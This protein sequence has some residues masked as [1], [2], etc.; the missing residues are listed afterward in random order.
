[1]DLK[2]INGI[3]QNLSLL[4]TKGEEWR[5]IPEYKN[6]GVLCSNMSRIKKGVTYKWILQATNHALSA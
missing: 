3:W 5:C 2:K 6:D 1:M 4:D